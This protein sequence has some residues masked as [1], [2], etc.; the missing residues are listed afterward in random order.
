M[1]GWRDG[2]WV[3]LL[4]LGAVGL[5]AT[6]VRLAGDPPQTLGRTLWLMLAGLGL[7][8]GGWLVAQAL[9]LDGWS[10]MA[11][12]WVSGAV[13]SEAMLPLARRWVEARFGLAPPRE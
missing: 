9:G 13:G 10:A 7:A 8:T 5:L 4:G 3:E 12:A 1:N 6:V 2:A 11:C